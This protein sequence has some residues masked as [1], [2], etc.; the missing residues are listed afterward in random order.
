MVRVETDDRVHTLAFDRPGAKNALTADA[1]T[2]LADAL[3]TAADADARAVVLTG[4]DGSFCAGGDIEAMA[5]REETPGEAY[6]RVRATLSELIETLLTL[7]LPVIP[8]VHGDAVA[9]APNVAATSEFASAA[10]DARLSE[11]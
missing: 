11:V 2:D 6:D 5:P 7:P 1:A 10:D 4:D 9:A 8:K 3:N